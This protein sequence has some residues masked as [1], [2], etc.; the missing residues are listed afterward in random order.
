MTRVYRWQC[1]CG[2]QTTSDVPPQCTRC[3]ALMVRGRIIRDTR[4]NPLTLEQ[5]AI[6]AHEHLI[7][8]NNA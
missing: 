1:W 6:R 8:E 3:K 7:G 2:T 5:R 4:R